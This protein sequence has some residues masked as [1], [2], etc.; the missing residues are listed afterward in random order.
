[1]A[2]EIADLSM[3]ATNNYLEAKLSETWQQVKA[4]N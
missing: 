3:E 2:N 1:M 4:F